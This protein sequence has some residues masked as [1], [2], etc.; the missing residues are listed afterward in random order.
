MG[1]ASPRGVA[2]R[3]VE[4]AESKA[5][6]MVLRLGAQGSLVVEGQTGQLAQVPAWPSAVA[7]AVGAGNAYCGAFLASWVETHQIAY[8]AACGSAAASLAVEQVGLPVITPAL[9]AEAHRR[10]ESL[11]VQAEVTSL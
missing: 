6:L 2:R 4:A 3:L 7:D 5:Q 11:L 1:N 8:A 9:W 10:A